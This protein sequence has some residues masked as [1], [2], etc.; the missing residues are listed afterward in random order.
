MKKQTEQLSALLQ[1]LI[2][3]KTFEKNPCEQKRLSQKFVDLC[4]QYKYIPIVQDIA[5]I[6]P[7][8]VFSQITSKRIKNKYIKIIIEFVSPSED[9]YC[10]NEQMFYAA[11]L[12]Q[13]LTTSDKIYYKQ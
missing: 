6:D 8:T 5:S 9:G 10:C 7:I 12:I 2:V 11:Q 1:C 13:S 4:T 3:L